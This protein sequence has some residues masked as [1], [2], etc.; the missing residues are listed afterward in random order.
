MLRISVA[1]AASRGGL[2]FA[3]VNNRYPPL[4]AAVG[5]EKWLD[6][7]Y[8]SQW[9]TSIDRICRER[10]EGSGPLT[11]PQPTWQTRHGAKPRPCGDGQAAFK[12][13]QTSPAGEVFR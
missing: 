3:S 13:K 10:G 9:Y 8:P 1:C 5:L 6:S 2:R 12:R 7:P 11:R 4:R